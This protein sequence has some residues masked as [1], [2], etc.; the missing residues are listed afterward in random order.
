[1]PRPGAAA[2]VER[3]LADEPVAYREPWIGLYATLAG[4]RRVATTSAAVA[5]VMAIAGLAI[6]LFLTS[7]NAQGTRART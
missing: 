2:E 3:W 1:M 4:R 5:S 6:V 7:A